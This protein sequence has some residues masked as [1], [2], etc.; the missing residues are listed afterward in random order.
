MSLTDS[1]ECQDAALLESLF[2][3]IHYNNTTI[4]SSYETHG[5]TSSTYHIYIY[6]YIYIYILIHPLL[7]HTKLNN[8]NPFAT[9]KTYMASYFM[10]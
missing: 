1:L 7:L 6:I 2:H 5:V 3:Y 4:R 9:H 8:F 10:S